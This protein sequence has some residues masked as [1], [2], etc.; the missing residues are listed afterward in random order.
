M[1]VVCGLT[2]DAEGLGDLRPG[3]ALLDRPRHGR[4]FQ[5]VREPPQGD[6]RGECFRR[7]VRPRNIDSISHMSNV[8]DILMSVKSV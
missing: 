3:P 6:D 1:T 5:P 8:F 2:G 7:I 4:A